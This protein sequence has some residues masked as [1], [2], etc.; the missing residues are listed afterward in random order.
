M[1][2]SLP[3]NTQA[4]LG[5]LARLF[6]RLGTTAF[7]GPAAHIAMMEQEIVTRRQWM[8]RDTF[9]DLLGLTHLI[10]GPN[11]TEMALFVGYLRHGLLGLL[12]AGCCFIL[13][14]MLI[15][16]ALAWLYVSMGSTPSF[17]SVLY[18]IKPVILAVLAQAVWNLGQT[19]FKTLSLQFLGVVILALSLLGHY[20]LQLLLGAGIFLALLAWQKGKKPG[21]SN[22]LPLVAASP[23]V[24]HPAAQAGMLLVPG[25]MDLFLYF[26]KIGAILYGSGYVLI[27]FLQADLV[28]C[29]GWLTQSQLLDAIAIGQM[30]PGPVFTTATFIGYLLC[31]PK[32]AVV[33]TL[34]I[35]M[36]AF[37]FVGLT[38]SL[39][40]RIRTSRIT[41]AFL[42]GVNVAAVA[43]MGMACLQLGRAAVMDPL[44][45][46]LFLGALLLLVKYRI[47]AIWLILAGGLLGILTRF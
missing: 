38:R 3:D 29:L 9:L 19:A 13:P 26:F 47:N 42:D 30:T 1:E 27:A 21:F 22:W 7:G 37:L 18:G 34:G 36:P 40:A 4:S 14:A 16:M 39:L 45:L 2:K 6:L 33:A 46:V 10:P 41:G 12:V 31:G 15:V 8:S 28:D 43:L 5:E 35:F 17:A 24:R 32:G 20:E 25:L 11:S 23:W 44:T